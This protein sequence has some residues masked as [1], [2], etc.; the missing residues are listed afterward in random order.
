MMKQISM[1]MGQ[2]PTRE[3]LDTIKAIKDKNIVFDDDC[4]EMSPA[5]RKAF[6]CAVA[7]RN[8]IKKITN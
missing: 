5:M 2:K 1:E 7:Q 8:R 6:R 3:Q 4:P